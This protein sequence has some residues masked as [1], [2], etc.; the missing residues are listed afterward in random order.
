MTFD[1]LLK[2]MGDNFGSMKL[3]DIAREFDVTPQVVSNWKSRNQVPYRYVKTLRKKIRN[4]DNK[5]IGHLGANP[6]FDYGKHAEK[7]EDSNF[8][9]FQILSLLYSSILKNKLIIIL[10]P[11]I[12]SILTAVHVVYFV[13]PGYTSSARI[14][15]ANNENSQ[16]SGFAAQFGVNIGTSATN[17]S[18][19]E[20]YPD[21]VK[22]RI[23]AKSLLKRKFQVSDSDTSSQT[24][25]EMLTSKKI[26]PKNSYTDPII[27]KGINKLHKIIGIKSSRKS[28]LID[29]TADASGARLARD[30]VLAVIDE[31]DLI[32]NKFKL[33]RI[34]EKRIF[35]ENRIEG[36]DIDLSKAEEE[37]KKFREQNRNISSS[38]ALLLQQDRL[39][40]DLSVLTEI[41][42]TL[43]NEY[44]Q[45]QIEEVENSR[46]FVVL[47]EPEIPL[48]RSS[49][50]RKRRVLTAIFLS[51]II[52]ITFVTV[53]AWALDN[54][55]DKIK[56]LIPSL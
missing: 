44:E 55:D 49:P 37:L 26:D 36:L 3:A 32:Q 42:I 17:I 27:F 23:L 46:M 5:S 1:E 20:L 25:L 53:K 6:N 4:I 19:A 29:I 9:I 38:P 8:D 41:Y 52:I 43:K 50:N 28:P 2:L 34:K 45:I 18:A 24:L 16:V 30:L 47:D 13:E 48:K 40:R 15:P 22:S 7:N 33:N 56:P 11:L 14:L 31:L 21:I 54:W 39:I 35:I 12:I 51:V 10:F